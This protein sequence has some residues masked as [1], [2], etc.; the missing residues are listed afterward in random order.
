MKKAF[1]LL[2]VLA[3]TLAGIAQTTESQPEP[4]KGLFSGRDKYLN[5]EAKL[6]RAFLQAG[7]ET[8]DAAQVFYGGAGIG[9]GVMLKNTMV[10]IGGAF[11]CVDLLDRSY[12]FPIFVEV[13][14]CFAVDP[15]RGVLLGA[16]GGWILGGQ[17][18]FPTEKIFNGQALMGTTVR[19]MKGPYGE[20]MVGYRFRKF[21]FFVAY[22]FRVVKYQTSY[23]DPQANILNNE[24]WKRN[25]HVV[26]GGVS[27]RLF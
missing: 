3:A 11:E 22:N 7:G 10:G 6:G 23:F 5:I 16:K 9:F 18:S 14:H 2:F 1:V 8:G 21:D 25:L 4:Y 17:R 15:S 19:S 26:M 12:S 13:R 20:A 27:F 24:P